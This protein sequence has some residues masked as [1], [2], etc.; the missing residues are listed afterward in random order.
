MAQNIMLLTAAA[1]S[2]GD[3]TAVAIPNKSP[4]LTNREGL[5]R[6]S[7]H[8]Q[9]GTAPA[10]AVDGSL[11]NSAW[12]ADIATSVVAAGEDLKTVIVYPYMRASVTTA[13]GSTEGFLS[14]SL[15]PLK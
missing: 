6:F 10:W 11:D 3:K 8:D 7:A 15:E 9:T 12:T 1:A 2:A 5:V 4:F 14:V 13:A